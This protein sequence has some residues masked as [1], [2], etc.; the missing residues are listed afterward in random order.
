MRNPGR[1]P[2]FLVRLELHRGEADHLPVHQLHGEQRGKRLHSIRN[3][4]LHDGP[5]GATRSDPDVRSH[6][7]VYPGGTMSHIHAQYSAVELVRRWPRSAKL[8][9]CALVFPVLGFLAGVPVSTLFMNLTEAFTVQGLIAFA[10]PFAIA[11]WIALGTRRHWVAWLGAVPVLAI[12][13]FV[14]YMNSATVDQLRMVWP[15]LFQAIIGPGAGAYLAKL[16]YSS[17]QPSPAQ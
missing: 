16:A 5:N 8:A 10:L 6:V 13:V 7:P 4:L 17:L 11:T 12:L 15:I 3:P 14:A 2:V 1:L 9:T